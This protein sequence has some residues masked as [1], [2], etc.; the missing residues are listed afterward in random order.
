MAK[1]RLHEG[2]EGKSRNHSSPHHGLSWTVGPRNFPQA[3]RFIAFTK[4]TILF[5]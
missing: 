2:Y 5:L 1:I 4:N 3:K